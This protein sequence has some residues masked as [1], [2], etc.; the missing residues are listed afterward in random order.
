MNLRIVAYLIGWV[1]KI[2]A[3]AMVIPGIVS[4]IYKEDTWY[5]FL[6]CAVVA[7]GAGIFLS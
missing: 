2:E 4:M 1:L 3:V 7:G 6:I 5:W